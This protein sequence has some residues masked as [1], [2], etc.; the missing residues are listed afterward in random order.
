MAEETE[1]VEP[2]EIDGLPGMQVIIPEGN[3]FDD[4]GWSDKKPEPTVK[5]PEETEKVPREKKEAAGTQQDDDEIVDELEYLERQT[6]YKSWDEIKALKTEAE[7]LRTK[8]QTPAEIKFAN[9]PSQKLFEAWKE[10]KE[11]EVYNLLHTQRE[12]KRAADLP[13]ADAIR[14]HIKMTN[15]NNP[16]FKSADVEDIFEDRYGLPKE[17]KQRVDE[18]REDFQDRMTEYKTRVDKVNRAIERDAFTAKQELSKRITELKPPEIPS[19]QQKQQGPTQEILEARKAFV[20]N[21]RKELPNQLR[22]IKDFSTTF[23]D[24]SVEFPISRVIKPE[25]LAPYQAELEAFADN[26][27]D[28]NTLFSK[29][30]INKDGSVNIRRMG[31]DLYLLDNRDTIFK[32][33]ATETGMQRMKAQ[34]K[35]NKNIKVDGETKVVNMDKTE[36]GSQAEAINKLWNEA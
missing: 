27:L 7:Q 14:M 19:H 10:G 15:E 22:E 4:G 20:E 32:N 5:Q 23:K 28:V 33:I 26:G 12:L 31:E 17:P 6:G 21:Y 2:K 9:E 24:D 1:V 13:S 29:R 34:A 11:D 18:D 30:W 36:K 25:D 3:L 35:I 8:T 16:N